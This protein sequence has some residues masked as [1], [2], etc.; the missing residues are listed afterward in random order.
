MSFF[1][2]SGPFDGLFDLNNDGS[3]DFLE[4]AAKNEFFWDDDGTEAGRSE[5]NFRNYDCDGADRNDV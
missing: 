2:N 4:G 5:E 3:L 1:D